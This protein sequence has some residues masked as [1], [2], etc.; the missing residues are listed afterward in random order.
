MGSQ[1]IITLAVIGIDNSNVIG[2]SDGNDRKL[3]K[4]NFTKPIYRIEKPS[5]LTFNA[6][7]TLNQLKQT[8]A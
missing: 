8:F 7:Q 3:V 1:P 2:S 4:S 6:S 5:F